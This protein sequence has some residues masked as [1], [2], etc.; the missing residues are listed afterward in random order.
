MATR[1]VIPYGPN[2]YEIPILSVPDPSRRPMRHRALY[3]SP[4]G[5]PDLIRINASA[6]ER[7]LALCGA[8]GAGRRT[9]MLDVIMLAVGFGFFALSVGY[10][11]ACDRL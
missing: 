10:A 6:C 9:E 5:F 3:G 7:K 2:L 8:A 1:A 11:I 4:R